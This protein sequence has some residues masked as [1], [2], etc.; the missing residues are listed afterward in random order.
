MILKNG[1][2][3][4]ESNID[5]IKVIMHLPAEYNRSAY[6]VYSAVLNNTSFT[7]CE[8]E[9]NSL[10]L[11]ARNFKT[12]TF[13]TGSVAVNGCPSN[14]E[15]VVHVNKNNV[16]SASC[17]DETESFHCIRFVSETVL[18]TCS[19]DTIKIISTQKI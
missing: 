19:K 1:S 3:I 15:M 6:P 7:L 11:C 12:I 14:T 17:F 18:Y 4:N 8:E 16:T 5:Y 9:Y 10:L 13:S 2:F